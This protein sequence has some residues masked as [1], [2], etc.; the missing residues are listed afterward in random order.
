M[1]AE[2]KNSK[3]FTLVELAIVITIIGLLIGG[4]LKGQEMLNISRI[5]ATV[6]QMQAY[7]AAIIAFKDKYDQMPGD[8]PNSSTRIPGC[9]LGCQTVISGWGRPGDGSVGAAYWFGSQQIIATDT[10]GNNIAPDVGY[11]TMNFWTHLYLAGFI[12]GVSDIGIQQPTRRAY[13]VTNPTT[14]LGGGL[15]TGM[16][17]GDQYYSIPP[18]GSPYIPSNT[19][20]ILATNTAT[21][22]DT[23][24]ANTYDPVTTNN[25]LT[26]FQASKLDEKLDDGLPGTGAMRGGGGDGPSGTSGCYVTGQNSYNVANGRRACKFIIAVMNIN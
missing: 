7:K 14:P 25:F 17:S 4:I 1:P 26:T 22:V 20:L 10:Q 23:I 15:M 16:A 6:A 9:T 12:S 24:F 18:S 21:G 3:G 2:R 19:F 8:M 13:G 5:N 11:E